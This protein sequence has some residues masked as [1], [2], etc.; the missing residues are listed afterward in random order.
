MP[1]PL[2]SR[3]D[4]PVS[5]ALWPP[6]NA[7]L[8]PAPVLLPPA[9]KRI[10]PEPSPAEPVKIFTFPELPDIA[11][12]LLNST[13]PD[14]SASPVA[15]TKTPLEIVSDLPDI[16]ETLPPV[17]VTLFPPDM[18][19]EPPA[20]FAAPPALKYM[21]PDPLPYDLP[22]ETYTDPPLC[23]LSPTF[24]SMLPLAIS[25]FPELNSIL[26]LYELTLLPLFKEIRPPLASELLPLCIKIEPATDLALSPLETTISPDRCVL[27][28]EDNN[29]SPLSK[30]PWPVPTVIAPLFCPSADDNSIFPE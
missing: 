14:A 18:C 6:P 2:C 5:T 10:L 13:P 28:P 26:P 11:F 9:T 19:I 16:K 7:R 3:I 25:D 23:L 22:D 30:T 29:I 21:S 15:I 17:P 12:P 1:C 20:S 4:P 24:I 8:P 27:Y